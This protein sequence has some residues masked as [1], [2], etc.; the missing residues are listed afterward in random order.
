VRDALQIAPLK[1]EFD[2]CDDEPQALGLL[3]H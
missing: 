1:R 2:L 3:V